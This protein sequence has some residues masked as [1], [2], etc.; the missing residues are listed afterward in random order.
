V[1]GGFRLSGQKREVS[2]KR[3][4]GGVEVLC[5]VIGDY[6]TFVLVGMYIVI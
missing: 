6:S 1:S 3:P 4:E 5:G 2:A